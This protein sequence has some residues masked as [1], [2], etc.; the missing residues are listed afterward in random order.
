MEEKVGIVV[1]QEEKTETGVQ[2]ENKDVCVACEHHA[3]EGHGTMVVPPAYSD[4]GKAAKDIFNKG[5]GYGV[6]KLDIKTKS[7][8]G[9][10]FIYSGFSNTDTGKSG[11]HLESK[12]KV[13]NLGLSFNQKWISDNTLSMDITMEDQLATG[14]K[15]GLD[16]MFVSSTGKK[17]GKVKSGYKRNHMNLGCDLDL[18][19]AGPTVHTAAVLAFSGW[20]GGYQMVYETAKS[21]T[22]KYSVT[23]GYQ[24]SDFQAHAHLNDST[25]FGA[26]IYHKANKNL[27]AAVN[28]AWTAGSNNTRFGIGTKYQL[29]KDSSLS[30]KVTN[31][32]VVGLGYTH[33]LRPGVNITL[34]AMINGKS[35]SSGGHKVGMAFEVEA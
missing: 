14:L 15:L 29:D 4:L 8:N 10:E 18:D 23:F 19:R 30:A 24:G 2:A 1:L 13:N 27:D 32:G 12:C 28:L 3:P 7:Q 6:M 35:V 17:S 20:V 34:S 22:T 26:S 25:E 9:I 33:T 11:A 16:T 5:Y 21:K 31:A